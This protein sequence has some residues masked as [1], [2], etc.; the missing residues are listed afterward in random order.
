MQRRVI[1]VVNFIGIRAK[2]NPLLCPAEALENRM[3]AFP[4]AGERR[5]GGGVG[6]KISLVD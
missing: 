3:P 4:V 6:Q 5:H 2:H 1:H